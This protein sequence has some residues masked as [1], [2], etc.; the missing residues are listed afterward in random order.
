MDHIRVGKI[1]GIG[2]ELRH[3]L[4]ALNKILDNFFTV[5]IHCWF[6]VLE[7]SLKTHDAIFYRN[8]DT[9]LDYH[10]MFGNNLTSTNAFDILNFEPSFQ[11]LNGYRTDIVK[12]STNLGFNNLGLASLKYNTSY[13]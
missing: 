13:I 4:E 7:I 2:I 3:D 12:I 8:H 9:L 6:K 10:P 11:S 1:Y 5:D